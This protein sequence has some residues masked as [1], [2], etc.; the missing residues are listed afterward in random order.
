[1]SN[2]VILGD[3]YE[4]LKTL[5]KNSVDLILTDP[6]YNISRPSNFKKNSDNKKFN[7]ISIEFG[8]WDESEIDL[9]SLFSEFKR[10][11]KSGGTIVIFYDVWKCSNLKRVAESYGFK[12]PRICQWVKTNPVP[13]NSKKNY[14]SNAI[15][16]FCVFVKDK[17]GVFNSK[18]DKGIYNY[19]ICHGHERTKHPTQKP[20]ELMKVLIEK[21][22]SEKDVVLDP[23]GGSGTTAVAALQ[24]KR[25]Y[26][27]IEKSTEYYNISLDRIQQYT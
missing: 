24:T 17:K 18:Y 8:Q 25:K 4:I 20:L 5:E 21:H 15:E 1:M 11:L 3:C 12:Q 14:L 23:F 2:K 7:N 6:P 13:I 22:S 19:P 16:F 9:D 26:I 10:I 27:L